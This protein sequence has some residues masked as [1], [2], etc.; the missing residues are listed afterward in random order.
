MVRKFSYLVLAGAL[1]SATACDSTGPNGDARM[2]VRLG[3]ASGSQFSAVLLSDGAGAAPLSL[4]AIDSINLRITAIEAL[5]TASPGDSTTEQR[6]TLSLR[7][8]ALT[9]INLL[10]L[11]STDSTAWLLARGDIP[12]GTYSGIRLRFDVATA[13]ITLNDTVSVGQQTWLPG[14]Y[15]LEVPSAQNNGIKVPMASIVIGSDSTAN[16]VLKFD[17]NTTVHTVATGSGK[18][19][20]SPVL[21]STVRIENQD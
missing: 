2:N 7:D 11:P 10:D 12:A 8:S 17:G 18:L 4:S 20:M 13:T 6:V 9:M 1:F 14:T 16:V 15:P 3:A 19:K 5:R 21:H